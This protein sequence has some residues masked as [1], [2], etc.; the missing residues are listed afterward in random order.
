M[1]TREVTEVKVFML[2]LN[3]MTQNFEANSIVAM[4]CDQKELERWYQSLKVDVY[5]EEKWSKSFKKDSKLE[6]FNPVEVGDNVG[7][8]QEWHKQEIIIQFYARSFQG[9]IVP[10]LVGEDIQRLLNF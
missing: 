1:I 10:E 5:K 6:W 7:I 3:P 8:T 2:R 9:F 4:S